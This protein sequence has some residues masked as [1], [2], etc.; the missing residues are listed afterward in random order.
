M[1]RL[2]AV[3]ALLPVTLL[4]W[5]ASLASAQGAEPVLEMW[6]GY[7][8][9]SRQTFEMAFRGTEAFLIVDGPWGGRYYLEQA[10]PDGLE[11]RPRKYGSDPRRVNFHFT[12]SLFPDAPT[13]GYAV[14][15]QTG[16]NQRPVCRYQLG[17][18]RSECTP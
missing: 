4:P 15:G 9:Y 7:D 6:R 3:L 5:G 13:R 10:S 18:V 12:I 17:D 1:D 11:S 14:I 16:V 2:L 8:V